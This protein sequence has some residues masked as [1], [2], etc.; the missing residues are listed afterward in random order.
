[1]QRSS[2]GGTEGSQGG[3]GSPVLAAADVSTP[4]S[5]DDDDDD[6]TVESSL[7]APLELDTSAA[8]D[9]SPSSPAHAPMSGT[10]RSS[11]RA[12]RASTSAT[13]TQPPSARLARTLAC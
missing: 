3:G 9:P 2:R 1:M 8:V 4:P 11:P 5:D 7:A 12:R 13:T 10:A 6:P